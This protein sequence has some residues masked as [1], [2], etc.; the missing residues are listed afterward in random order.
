VFLLEDWRS[1]AA[2]FEL[3]PIPT[4]AATDASLEELSDTIRNVIAEAIPEDD[5]SPWVLQLFSQDDTD[6]RDYLDELRAYAAERVPDNPLTEDFLQMME[7]HLARVGRPEGLF[8][9]TAVTGA[10]WHARRRRMRAVI[11]RRIR[12]V[13]SCA[14]AS[15]P[16]RTA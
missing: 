6:L 2:V 12:P 10:R 1:V 11:Y 8:V 15:P 9:D 14:Q 5:G 3:D 16:T 4:E 7:A 13:L